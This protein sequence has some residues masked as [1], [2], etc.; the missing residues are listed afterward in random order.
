MNVK[1]YSRAM[2]C[3]FVAAYLCVTVPAHAGTIP[4]TFDVTYDAFF[5]STPGPDNLT[6]PTTASGYGTFSPFGEGSFSET[7][8]VTFETFT[9][10]EFGPALVDLTFTASFNGGI[11]TFTGTDVH[12]HD[13]AGN[14]ISETM[15]ILEGAGVFEGATGFFLPDTEEITPSGNTSPGYF[16]TFETSG[17]GQISAPGL[18]ATPEPG[19]LPL[20]CLASL[21]LAGFRCRAASALRKCRS[22]QSYENSRR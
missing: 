8:S 20:F 14:F 10:G 13:S 16:A 22:R 9:T 7:G 1:N 18:V 15:T 5:G 3:L 11:D 19:S 17:T 21:V 6:V 2:A 4:V 12:L